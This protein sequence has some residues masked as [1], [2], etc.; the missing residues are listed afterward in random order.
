[1]QVLLNPSNNIV[2]PFKQ[3]LT[4]TLLFLVAI[5]AFAIDE[6]FYSVVLGGGKAHFYEISK[7]LV[8]LVVVLGSIAVYSDFTNSHTIDADKPKTSKELMVDAISFWYLVGSISLFVTTAYGFVTRHHWG[9]FEITY[10]SGFYT[11]L[12]QAIYCVMGV[13][14]LISYIASIDPYLSEQQ[15]LYMEKANLN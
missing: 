10:I 9:L 7:R 3:L 8:W 1:M 5:N 12:S 2:A 6:G 13:I 11:W 4:A 15:D 14:G